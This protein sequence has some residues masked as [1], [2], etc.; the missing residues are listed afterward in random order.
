[1]KPPAPPLEEVSKDKEKGNT[2]NELKTA[3]HEEKKKRK[4]KEDEKSSND[5]EESLSMLKG[6]QDPPQDGSPRD[7]E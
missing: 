4:T 6:S 5:K 1:M 3:E 2:D 7:N